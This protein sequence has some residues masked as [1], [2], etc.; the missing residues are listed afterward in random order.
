MITSNDLSP[1]T[2]EPDAAPPTGR[3]D[4]VS[5]LMALSESLQRLG[6]S[7]EAYQLRE[8]AERVLRDQRT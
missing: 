6:Y 4:A 8:A 2:A 3:L 1:A 7:Y 5:R